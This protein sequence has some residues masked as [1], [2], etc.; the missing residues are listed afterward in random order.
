M[1][2]TEEFHFKPALLPFVLSPR[3]E[4]TGR[5]LQGFSC[6][7]LCALVPALA[8]TMYCPLWEAGVAEAAAVAV[9]LWPF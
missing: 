3:G 7:V 1:K 9:C 8:G 4:T 5:I 6:G 2:N